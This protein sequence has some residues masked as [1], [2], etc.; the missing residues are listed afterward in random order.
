MTE[1]SHA[2]SARAATD[3]TLS[4]D[5]GSSPIIAGSDEYPRPQ[6][7]GRDSSGVGIASPLFLC[8]RSCSEQDRSR[9]QHNV[10]ARCASVV[11]IVRD[12]QRASCTA[13]GRG[14]ESCSIES[15]A[16]ARLVGCDPATGEHCSRSDGGSC[17][18]VRCFISHRRAPMSRK[19]SVD[20][21]HWQDQASGSVTADLYRDGLCE[22]RSALP[23]AFPSG[24]AASRSRVSGFGVKAVPSRLR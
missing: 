19:W 24:T 9:D 6:C 13:G 8:A 11:A 10:L 23:A 22:A 17:W 21:R 3:R 16:A 2:H 12:V 5:A 20:I 7:P 18:D 15:G 1:R 14:P 4:V